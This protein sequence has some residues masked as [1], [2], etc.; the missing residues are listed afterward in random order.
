MAVIDHAVSSLPED[1]SPD[2]KHHDHHGSQ[3]QGACDGCD[4]GDGQ[5][6]MVLPPEAA[7]SLATEDATEGAQASAEDDLEAAD[8]AVML[9]GLPQVIVD[10]LRRLP[11]DVGALDAGHRSP[12]RTQGR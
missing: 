1:S 4:D 3:G 10:A 9:E 5:F 7:H 12:G 2:F 8:Q 11:E 6:P